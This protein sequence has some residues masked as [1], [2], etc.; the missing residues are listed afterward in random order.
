MRY[1]IISDIH[2]NL[3][4]L[5]VVLRK[6]DGCDRWICLGDIVG[7]GPNPNECC[8]RVRALNALCVQ[9]NHDLAALGQ[10]DLSWFN[11][12]AA[13]AILWTQ[14][15][16][17]A[18]NR[19]F[20]QNVPAMQVINDENFPFTLVHGSPRDPTE[21]YIS[22]AQEADAIFER[23]TTPLCLVGHTH[24]AECYVRAKDALTCERRGMNAGGLIP[25]KK[26]H[27]YII[28]CGSVGQPR[29]RNP[30]TSC[31]LLDT[32][33]RRVEIFRL[34]YPIEATQRKMRAAGLP[35][36]LWQRLEWGM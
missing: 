15:Q 31:G 26:H 23:L 33:A 19:A 32:Q 4:A 22:S 13:A 5:E 17:T 28:N 10:Y 21:E 8:E 18:A 3:E 1:G 25:L 35:D 27:H 7:Y 16:L 9:G 14:K 20:L 36:L 11:D 30:Q 12:W 2:G 34:D 24:V 29:D 6:L